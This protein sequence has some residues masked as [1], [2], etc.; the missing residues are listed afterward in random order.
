MSFS[1][2]ES[3]RPCSEYTLDQTIQK[4]H[5]STFGDTA[6][7]SE[8]ASC[9]DGL[10]TLGAA[11][12]ASATTDTSTGFDTPSPAGT[13]S[14]EPSSSPNPSSSNSSRYP[15]EDWVRRADDLT[16]D[17]SSHPVNDTAPFGQQQSATANMM[18]VDEDALSAPTR[19]YVPPILTVDTRSQTPAPV[20]SVSNF[21]HSVQMFSVN[22]FLAPPIV[23][24]VPATP[25]AGHSIRVS[26]RPATPVSQDSPTAMCISPGTSH[27]SSPVSPMTP[28]KQQRLTMGPRS[29]CEKCRMGVRGHWLHFN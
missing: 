15:S 4:R 22:T 14:A 21:T 17:C 13:A 26:D 7:S 2:G 12:G 24:V 6:S 28:R 10:S 29:D 3:R 5:L 8:G 27:S 11:F 9:Y 16:L 20:Q 23:N 25:V 19:P 1:N 18:N